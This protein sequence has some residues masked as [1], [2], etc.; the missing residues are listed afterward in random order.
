MHANPIP[1]LTQKEFEKFRHYVEENGEDECWPWLGPRNDN[2]YGQMNV[3]RVITKAHRIA[4]RIANN[5]DPIGLAVAHRC[6]NPR[7]VNPKHLFKAT[8]AE[9]N[10]DRHS[11]GRSLGA[12]KGE[13][14]HKSK[15]TDEKV[16]EIRNRYSFRK[17][18]QKNLAHEFGVTVLTIQMVLSRRIW[19]HI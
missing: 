10:Q 15:L 9:N 4:Y 6:D 18:L 19:K 8:I 7:C 11:K 14:H 5:S 13:E 2:G 1:E 16:R 12:H 17:V 3:N